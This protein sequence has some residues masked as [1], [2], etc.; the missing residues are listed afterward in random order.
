[1]S[2]A[3][4]SMF[5]INRLLFGAREDGANAGYYRALARLL[6]DQRFAFMNHGYDDGQEEDGELRAEDHL[7]RYS[8][9]L[10]RHVLAG[11]DLRGRRVL[12]VG[13]GRGGA[14]SY[15]VR[16][17]QPAQVV[18]LDFCAEAIFLC[19]RTHRLPGLGFLQ[20]DAQKLPLA[21]EVFD[22]VLNIE[23]CHYYPNLSGFLAEVARVLKP[24]GFLC[25][26]DTMTPGGLAPFERE[27]IPGAGFEI[28]RSTDITSAV[29]QGI[30]RNRQQFAAFCCSMVSAET[31]N[32]GIIEQL[33]RSVNE[34]LYR[35]YL[36][37]HSIY[38]S[39]L[40]RKPAS[41]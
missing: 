4:R 28:V 37:R 35:R 3:G 33:L 32:R 11:L 36:R 2:G 26:T 1:M 24:G 18:S 34:D 41:G 23:S 16:Y 12:D 21:G 14:S 30:E 9:R 39:W 8:I 20:A 31:G 7:W 22:V 10:V 27:L 15:I 29:A 17:H 13:C 6:P 19:A 5:A 38:H 25:L 40:L